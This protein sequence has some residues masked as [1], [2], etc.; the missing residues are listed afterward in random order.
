MSNFNS[1]I[2]SNSRYIAHAVSLGIV[3]EPVAKELKVLIG[4]YHTRTARCF[5]GFD[6]SSRRFLMKQEPNTPYRGVTA[7]VKAEAQKFWTEPI[8]Y[9][10]DR[11]VSA[12]LLAIG[13]TIL[14]GAVKVLISTGLSLVK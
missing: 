1:E 7:C 10:L 2:K 13:I 11:F 5:L 8:G 12:C 9:A 4:S 3:V 6:S 14:A